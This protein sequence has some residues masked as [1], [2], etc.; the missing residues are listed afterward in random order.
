MFSYFPSR[1]FALVVLSLTFSCQLLCSLAVNRNECFL[2]IE[3]PLLLTRLDHNA[4]DLPSSS[5]TSVLSSLAP[6]ALV[7]SS[8]LKPAAVTPSAVSAASASST[9]SDSSVSSNLALSSTPTPPP[10]PSS[11]PRARQSVRS[12]SP[13]SLRLSP[14][15]SQNASDLP[16]SLAARLRSAPVTPLTRTTASLVSSEGTVA[17]AVP[18]MSSLP[19]SRHSHDVN[20]HPLQP[21]LRCGRFMHFVARLTETGP[22]PLPY[23]PLLGA[24][25]AGWWQLPWFPGVF[26]SLMALNVL[27]YAA[28]QPKNYASFIVLLV[29]NTMALVPLFGLL[30]ARRLRRLLFSSTDYRMLLWFLACYCGFTL[31]YLVNVLDELGQHPSEVQFLSDTTPLELQ[32]ILRFYLLGVFS[33]HLFL[34]I[35]IDAS[36]QSRRFSKFINCL[37]LFVAL[38]IT[39]IV[40]VGE[41]PSIRWA[42]DLKVC[43]FQRFSLVYFDLNSV[44]RESILCLCSRLAWMLLSDADL[45]LHPPSFHDVA[46][47]ENFALSCLSRA[48]QRFHP[49]PKSA[50]YC[51]GFCRCCRSRSFS[52]N[53]FD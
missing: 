53:N 36:D 6:V 38:V 39:C 11:R 15:S 12:S 52:S 5:R 49:C 51:S 20:S 34:G 22:S 26:A 42:P 28:G 50:A 41:N 30:D 14:S 9:S 8:V 3:A 27:T 32:L 43:P 46:L 48:V 29:L 16:P 1:Y 40:V 21:L 2:R 13:S 24:S 19:I 25:V 18:A 35:S 4:V 17:V 10:F 37:L 45:L 31:Y 47:P 7:S 33:M 44:L 23:E